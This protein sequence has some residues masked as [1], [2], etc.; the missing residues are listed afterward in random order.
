[1]PAQLSCQTSVNNVLIHA[2]NTRPSDMCAKGIWATLACTERLTPTKALRSSKAARLHR[3][4]PGVGPHL[5]PIHHNA[6][7]LRAIRE[8]RAAPEISAISPIRSNHHMAMTCYAQ[9]RLQVKR[10]SSHHRSPDVV[11]PRYLQRNS[12]EARPTVVAVLPI[13]G[14]IAP[15]HH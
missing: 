14:R 4:E 8:H 15:I 6:L 9:R 2:L 11:D 10:F 1:V 7:R 5:L 13:H 12:L 3:R